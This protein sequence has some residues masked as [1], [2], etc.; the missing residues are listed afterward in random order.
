VG[1]FQNEKQLIASAIAEIDMQQSSLRQF[2]NMEVAR[3]HSRGERI[4]SA[5]E[6]YYQ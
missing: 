5:K 6:T 1:Y 4:G 3:A 2:T